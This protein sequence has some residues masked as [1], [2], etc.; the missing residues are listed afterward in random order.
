MNQL[1]VGVKND[2]PK[3]FKERLKNFGKTKMK[4]NP[5]E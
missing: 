4:S 1:L 3:Y 2:K 5:S